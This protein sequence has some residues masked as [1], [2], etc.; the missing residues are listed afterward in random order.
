MRSKR[1]TKNYTVL[2][3]I[4]SAELRT[5]IIQIQ[6]NVNLLPIDLKINKRNTLL[7]RHNNRLIR[8][9]FRLKTT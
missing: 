7:D 9:S 1:L 3:K 5:K 8:F 2:K 6:F 4:T